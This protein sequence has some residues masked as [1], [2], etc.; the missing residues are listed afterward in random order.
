M[1]VAARPP[2]HPALLV[3]SGAV[4][5][6]VGAALAHR[7]FEPLGAAGTVLVRLVASALIL[8]VVVRP[9]LRGLS[10]A[11]WWPVVAFGVALA[12]MNWSYY[13]SIERIPMGIAVTVEFLGPLAVA[14][15]GSRRPL[16]VVWALLAGA[17][18]VLLTTGGHGTTGEPLDRLG[19]A[20]A[21]VAGVF[22]ALYILLSKR[23]GQVLPGVQ[24]LAISSV[25]AALL[26]V[27][28]GTA[29]GGASLLDP[30]LLA[31]GA[32]VGLMSSALPYGL[33]MMALRFLRAATFGVLMSLE[34]AIA[35][36]V[37]VLLLAEHLAPLQWVAVAVVCVASA[38]ATLR[39]T[40]PAPVD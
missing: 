21:A 37:G 13:A 15:A 6:Q 12:A 31:I 36:L 28:V 22:W 35:S 16:D 29:Q 18:V 7:L 32:A 19:L 10:P 27:P 8:V 39:T 33:E 38:G 26:I 20:L 14:L 4:S 9:R 34:P 2:V 24:G 23:V 11:Q 1:H 3:L 25:L 30:H 40:G 17:G 5:V